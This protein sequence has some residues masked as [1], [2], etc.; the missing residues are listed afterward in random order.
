ML[1]QVS[2]A[3]CGEKFYKFSLVTFNPMKTVQI[4]LLDQNIISHLDLSP[5]LC[6]NCTDGVIWGHW[7]LFLAICLSP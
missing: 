4:I 1:A 3:I 2:S 5:K 6:R 7:G